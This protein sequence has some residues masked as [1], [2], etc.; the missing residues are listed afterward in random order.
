MYDHVDK[1]SDKVQQNK[2]K[3]IDCLQLGHLTREGASGN[4]HS[5]M[6]VTTNLEEDEITRKM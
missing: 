5:C 4:D 1:K 2:A 6:H 3:L